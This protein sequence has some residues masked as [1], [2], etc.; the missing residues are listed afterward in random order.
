MSTQASLAAELDNMVT[1]TRHRQIA[2]GGR[3]RG[4]SPAG[5]IAFYTII[6]K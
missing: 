2:V 3:C 6:Y 4:S 5:Y 1:A